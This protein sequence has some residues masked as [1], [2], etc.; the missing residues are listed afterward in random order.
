MLS[1]PAMEE[2]IKATHPDDDEGL[3]QA[4]VVSYETD[5]ERPRIAAFTVFEAS[6]SEINALLKAAGFGNIARVQHAVQVTEIPLLGTGRT[7]FC[8]N[9]R[10]LNEPSP[11]GFT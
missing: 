10:M 6:T 11:F 9:E 1:L 7:V 4:A 8:S 2:A 3:S 5:G